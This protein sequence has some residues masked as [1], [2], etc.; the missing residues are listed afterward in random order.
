MTNK[1]TAAVSLCAV[2]FGAA[3]SFSADM[4]EGYRPAKPYKPLR[5]HHRVVHRA[6]LVECSLLQIDYRQPNVP[7]TELVRVC[8]PP[9]DMTPISPVERYS[10][11]RA[12]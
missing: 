4:I 8:Y 3:P 1:L 2:L 12:R 10:G 7:H 11:Y 5:T 6:E 9:L